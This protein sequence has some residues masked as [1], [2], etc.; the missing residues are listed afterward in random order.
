MHRGQA[1][2]L[3]GMVKPSQLVIAEREV[4]VTPFDI[5]A[6]ALEHV[7]KR[8]RLLHELM[9]RHWAQRAQGPTG[10]KSGVR[11]RSVSARSGAPAVT[12]RVK[13]TRSRSYD[14]IRGAC[15]A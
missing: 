14:G 10:S 3:S 11:R 2:P 8:S 4:P 12:V 9:L 1:R 13:A 6:G 5:G 15:M 7:C